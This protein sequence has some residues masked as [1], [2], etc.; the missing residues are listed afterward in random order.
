MVYWIC[1]LEQDVVGHGKDAIYINN[2]S[3][4]NAN[5]TTTRSG[6]GFPESAIFVFE[7]DL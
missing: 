1:S 6:V 3:V 5:G 7:D 2:P 4:G